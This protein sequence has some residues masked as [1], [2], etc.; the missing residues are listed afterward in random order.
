[1]VVS[2]PV[3]SSVVKPIDSCILKQGVVNLPE[4]HEWE[5][6]EEGGYR[7]MGICDH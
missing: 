7:K 4:G 3:L 1:M 2:A 6:G 5:G